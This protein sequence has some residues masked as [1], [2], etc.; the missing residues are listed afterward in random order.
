MTITYGG[1]K[2]LVK[3]ETRDCRTD[4]A[5]WLTMPH[6]VPIWASS[7]HEARVKFSK[8]FCECFGNSLEYRILGIDKSY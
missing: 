4:G 2:Y 6:R 7:E 8:V 1:V 5:E 3:Y